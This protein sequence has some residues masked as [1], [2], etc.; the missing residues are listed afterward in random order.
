[1]LRMCWRHGRI[2]IYRTAPTYLGRPSAD[3]KT[4]SKELIG[5]LGR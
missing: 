1:M 4:F 3:G 2:D 5:T